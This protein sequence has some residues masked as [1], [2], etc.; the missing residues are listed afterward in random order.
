[1]EAGGFVQLFVPLTNRFVKDWQ[2]KEMRQ[3]NLTRSISGYR[4][5]CANEKW[6]GRGE[7]ARI[8]SDAERIVQRWET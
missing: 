7:E 3:I 5:G 2:H 1:M 8:A 6:S 4:D